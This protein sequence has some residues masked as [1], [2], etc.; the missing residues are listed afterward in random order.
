MRPRGIADAATIV[1]GLQDEIRRSAESRYD[2]QLHGVLM[3][4][5]GMT[6]LEVAKLLAKLLGDAPRTVEYWFHGFEELGLAGLLEGERSG[7]PRRLNEEQLQELNAVLRRGPREPGMGGNLWDG[8]SLAAWIER[9]Y[10]LRLGVRQ[11]QRLFRQLGFRPRK[12]RPLVARAD[13]ERQQA[14]K[15]NSKR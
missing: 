9:E 12:P 13:P 11:C 3:V 8:K 10:G 4:A 14:H 2:H 5:Q 6:C 15:T 1:L 7:R